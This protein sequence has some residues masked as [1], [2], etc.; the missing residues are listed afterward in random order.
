MSTRINNRD[1]GTLRQIIQENLQRYTDAPIITVHLI[2]SFESGLSTNNS[3]AD[4]TVFNFAQPYLGGTPI[5]ELAKALRWAGC[6]SVMTIASARVPIVKFV[7][8]GIQ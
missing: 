2:G 5:E 7:A 1:V 4:F 3:D 6:Q 8:W